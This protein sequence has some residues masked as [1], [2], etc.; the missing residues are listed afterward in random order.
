MKCLQ[1][2]I[3]FVYSMKFNFYMRLFDK[4]G[5]LVQM[6]IKA[7]DDLIYFLIYFCITLCFFAIQI[8]IFMSGIPNYDGIGAA[9]YFMLALQTS[10]GHGDIDQ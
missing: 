9:L 7:F 5:F 10:T 2:A 4:F 3:V 6:I 8:S 1:C